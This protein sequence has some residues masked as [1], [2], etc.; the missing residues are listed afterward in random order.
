MSDWQRWRDENKQ[1]WEE[2]VPIHVGPNGYE[3]DNFEASPS[4]ISNVVA[5]D[6]PRLN[7]GVSLD[8]LD[9]CHL[10]CHIGTDTLSLLR[11]GAKSVTGLD[12]SPLALREARWLFAQVGS[13]GRFVESDVFDAV[14]SLK[15]QYDLVYASVGAINWINR[16]AD[17]MKVAS[18]LLRP[19]GSLYIRDTHPLFMAIDPERN[20]GT[21][22]IRFDYFEKIEPD[23]LEDDQTYTGDGTKLSFTKAHEWVHSVSEIMMGA[24]NAGLTINAVWEDDF[25]DWLAFPGMIEGQHGDYR[26]PPGMPRIPFYFAM[27][28]TK[29]A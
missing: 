27:H 25:A 14:S 11:L 6:K 19:G 12:F 2:R 10:Q 24:I 3:R 15:E 17:W 5:Y 20:D 22:A 4:H 1:N 26:L 13:A 18:D 7:G 28:A 23:T 21:L 29:R 8:G 9:V 16:I